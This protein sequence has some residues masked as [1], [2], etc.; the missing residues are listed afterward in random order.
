MYNHS[1]GTLQ[2][3]Y[4]ATGYKHLENH[5]W[6]CLAEREHAG[7]FSLLPWGILTSHHIIQSWKL[8]HS[9]KKRCY[10]CQQQQKRPRWQKQA[11]FSFWRCSFSFSPSQCIG[12]LS[13]DADIFGLYK[14]QRQV[15]R[16]VYMCLF[17]WEYLYRYISEYFL[18]GL[19]SCDCFHYTWENKKKKH[20]NT[21]P[22]FPCCRIE[23][24]QESRGLRENLKINKT[25]VTRFAYDSS[26]LLFALWWV[27]PWPIQIWKTFHF[28]LRTS[29]PHGLN[30]TVLLCHPLSLKC[31]IIHRTCVNTGAS[32]H[33]CCVYTDRGEIEIYIYRYIQILYWK[34]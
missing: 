18:L 29:T 9:Q 23:T 2:A 22:E 6:C 1:D 25:G 28:V 32:V 4:E 13:D 11:P 26:S 31:D 15:Q 21:G 8:S 27:L 5:P 12:T 17:W 24:F 7:R 10:F 14:N 20:S 19:K 33:S 30:V 3:P 34:I 16:Y